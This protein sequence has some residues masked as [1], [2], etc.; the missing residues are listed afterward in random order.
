M[1][2]M[3]EGEG[4]KFIPRHDDNFFDIDNWPVSVEDGVE[5]QL[6]LLEKRL[7]MEEISTLYKSIEKY[8]KTQSIKI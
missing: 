3:V 7:P 2:I 4:D 6:D 5:H 1:L 8:T